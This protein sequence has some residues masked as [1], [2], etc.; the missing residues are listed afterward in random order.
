ML[1]LHSRAAGFPAAFFI[2]ALS[3]IALLASAELSAAARF[4]VSPLLLTLPADRLA[5][6]LTLV[7]KGSEPVTVQTELVSWNQ[8]SGEDAYG[9]ADGLLVSPPIVRIAAEATQVLRAGRLKPAPAPVREQAYRLRVAEVPTDA[10]LQPG[11]VSTVIQMSFPLFVPPAGKL[12]APELAFTV[13]MSA[14]GDLL[15]KVSNSGVVHGKLTQLELLQS[16]AALAQKKL[17]FYVLAG[18]RRQLAWAGALKGASPG[19][20][21]LKI[22]ADGRKRLYQQDLKISATPFPA[23]SAPAPADPAP[24]GNE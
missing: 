10:T 1:N 20:A 3:A 8:D 11:A 17:N 13:E 23:P 22:H 9:P 21:V 15:L 18:A 6:S 24:A 12:H 19:S 5:T 7:N 2:G 16:G 14:S 4:A